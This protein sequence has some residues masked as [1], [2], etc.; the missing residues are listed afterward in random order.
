MFLVTPQQLEIYAA[1]V[2]SLVVEE[3]FRRFDVQTTVLTEMPYSW[4][5]S[6]CIL[7]KKC[8][9]FVSEYITI[10]NIN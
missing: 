10:Y 1:G 9:H 6:P 4:D 2:T 5:T 8:W 3:C 7:E